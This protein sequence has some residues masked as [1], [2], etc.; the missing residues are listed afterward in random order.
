MTSTHTLRHTTIA[1]VSCQVTNVGAARMRRLLRDRAL[2]AMVA[3]IMMTAGCAGSAGTADATGGGGSSG[4]SDAVALFAGNWEGVFD[5]VMAAGDMRLA[6]NHDADVWS[7][8]VLLD[9]E[10]ESIS[11]PV[12]S[13]A[14]IEEGCTFMTFLEGAEVIFNARIEE[15]TMTG[16]FEAYAESDLVAEGTFALKK[17]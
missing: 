9:I 13:F 6:L 17:K 15:G 10:G 4:G 8:E 14:L 11:A 16:T 12:E 3:L 2:T 5:I 1:Q 7:G